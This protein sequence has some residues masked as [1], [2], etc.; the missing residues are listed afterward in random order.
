MLHALVEA[1]TDDA[2]AAEKIR[3][4]GDP[5]PSRGRKQRIPSK[6]RNFGGRASERTEDAGSEIN[7][8]SAEDKEICQI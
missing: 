8:L 4:A 2:H 5:A 6:S 3:L 1:L 7:G